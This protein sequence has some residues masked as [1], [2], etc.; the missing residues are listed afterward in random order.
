MASCNLILVRPMRTYCI[1]I[2]S[3]V[4]S[5][6]DNSFA[7]TEAVSAPLPT[8]LISHAPAPVY[9]RDVIHSHRADTGIYL[10]RVQIESGTVTQ[11][12]VGRSAGDRAFDIAAA[13]ALIRWRFKPGA[14]PFRKIMSVRM[15]PPQ[16]DQETLVKVPVTFYN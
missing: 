14:V 12:L 1:L 5:L 15:S 8:R 2:L 13:K 6:A 9:P 11:V 10:L 3:L 16:T 7:T 4:T